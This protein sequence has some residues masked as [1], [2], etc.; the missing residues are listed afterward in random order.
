MMRDLMQK[1]F[2]KIESHMSYLKHK[3]ILIIISMVIVC[4]IVWGFSCLF[5]SKQSH[6]AELTVYV[7]LPKK[8]SETNELELP[9]ATQAYQQATLYARSNGYISEWYYDIGST[10]EEGELLAE[11][12]APDLDAQVEQAKAAVLR[13]EAQ[14]KVAQLNM[15][16]SA[17]L[18][19]TN[20]TS[21][22]S[23]DQTEAEYLSADADL[24]SQQAN[25]EKL[26][27]LQDFEEIIAPF[28]GTITSRKIDRGDLVLADNLGG[29]YLYQMSDQSVLRIFV[30][31]PQSNAMNIQ[32]GDAVEVKFL[33][34]PDAPIKATVVRSSSAIDPASR[35]LLVEVNVD[36]QQAKLYPGMYCLVRFFIK[37]LQPIY[38]VP[39][40]TIITRATGSF[41]AIV[42]GDNTVHYQSV[43]LDLGKI[44]EV[45]KGLEGT[46]KLIVNPNAYLTE[47][48]PVQAKTLE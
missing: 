2:K 47:K 3:P 9:S 37:S 38:E 15:V 32:D 40:N 34:F 7:V 1:L 29:S 48:M 11:I 25:F 35:T 12:S 30:N 24:K 13:S 6:N 44:V 17:K 18:V 23:Y 43:T 22:Q 10:V 26:R 31:V 21:R 39:A 16:R 8:Q 14:L 28:A 33:E 45:N 4:G 42:A 36:N 5:R 27:A 41:V 20:D 46:E 19:K